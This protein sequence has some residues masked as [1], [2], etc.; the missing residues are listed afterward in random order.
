[1]AIETRPAVPE[2]APFIAWVM[3]EAARSHI[4]KGVWDHLFPGDEKSRL[5]ILA[6]IATTE[7]PHF[8]HY[9]RFRLLEVDGEAASA[10]SA[11]ENA[12]FGAVHLNPAI[13]D[14]L[15][16]RGWTVERMV[17]MGERTASFEVLGYPNPD[18]LWIVEWV[19]TRPE[20]RGRALV[21][22]LLNEIL[23]QGRSSGFECAQIG[24]L[25]GNV[26]AANVYEAVGFRWMQD[27]R[28]PDFE[29]DYGV[30]GLAR[31]QMAL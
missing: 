26:R 21:R 13:A 7:K 28:H 15:L 16:S 22:R 14:V 10:L 12:E 25:L 20:F 19:A 5:E 1:L 9:S 31:M 29:R 17:A 30:P 8:A 24:Y 18:G 11:Y 2:D 6:A 23:D 4:E 27:Y 3:Q